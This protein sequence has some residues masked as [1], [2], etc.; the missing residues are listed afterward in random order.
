MP[1]Q[2]IHRDETIRIVDLVT[3]PPM[4]EFTTF[5]NCHIV[6]PAVLLFLGGMEASNCTWIGT[7]DSVLWEIPPDRDWIV[8]AIGL[9]DT[10]FEGCTFEGVGIAGYRQFI[11]Q[12]RAVLPSTNDEQGDAKPKADK[13]TAPKSG[14][15][16]SATE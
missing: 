5:E 13:P 7:A 15:S 4:I 6:G 10:R 8:G 11:E 16:E 14:S 1:D 12:I 9:R 3:A 2:S